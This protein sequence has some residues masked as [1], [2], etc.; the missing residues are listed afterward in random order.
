MNNKSERLNNNIFDLFL[1]FNHLDDEIVKEYTDF[2]DKEKIAFYCSRDG[3]TFGTLDD[4]I[5]KDLENSSSFA[6]MLTKNCLGSKWCLN[7]YLLF[8]KNN[9]INMIMPI[10]VDDVL[11]FK[12]Q[13]KIERINDK[14]EVEK[15]TNYFKINRYANNQ[16]TIDKD[17]G[18][19]YGEIHDALVVLWKKM[20]TLYVNSKKTEKRSFLKAVNNIILEGHLESLLTGKTKFSF[21]KLFRKKLNFTNAEELYIK[22]TL[23][24]E[25]DNVVSEDVL[26]DACLNNN[27]LIYSSAGNGKTELL[28][29]IKNTFQN[30]SRT[31]SLFIECSEFMMSG[32]ASVFSYLYDVIKRKIKRRFTEDHLIG[33]LSDEK[34]II[35]WDG[36]DEIV[37]PNQRVLFIERL[38]EFASDYTNVKYVISS[39]FYEFDD[40]DLSLQRYR[41]L[42]F[43]KEEINKYINSFYIKFDVNDIDSFYFELEKINNDIISNPLFLSQIIVIYK[44]E[45]IIPKTKFEILEKT[46]SYLLQLDEEKVFY[47]DT[48]KQNEMIALVNHLLPYLVFRI[49]YLKDHDP[50]KR[51]VHDELGLEKV[52]LVNKTKDIEKFLESRSFYADEEVSGLLQVFI[53]YYSAEY[54]Y[55]ECFSFESSE[56]GKKLLNKCL[57]KNELLSVLLCKIDKECEHDKDEYTEHLSYLL[58]LGIDYTVYLSISSTLYNQKITEYLVTSNLLTKTI[59]NRDNY[60]YYPFYLLHKYHLDNALIEASSSLFK[61][62][63]DK[64]IL[65]SLLRDYFVIFNDVRDGKGL[66]KDN[67]L[68][69][70]Q[71]YITDHPSY[72]NAL[73]GLF[74]DVHLDGFINEENKRIHPFF[75]NLYLMGKDDPSDGLGE[76]DLDINFVDELNIYQND[77][78]DG[79]EHIGVI[80]LDYDYQRIVKEL[81]GHKINKV[82]GI[83]FNSSNESKLTVLPIIKKNL[84]LLVI[85]SS[86]KELDENS[87]NMFKADIGNSS[88]YIEHGVKEIT[89]AIN[90]FASVYLPNSVTSFKE[91]A[92]IHIFAKKAYLSNS[93]ETITR[94]LFA[95]SPLEY[96]KLPKSLIAIQHYAFSDCTHLKKLELPSTLKFLDARALINTGIPYLYIPQTVYFFATYTGKYM[97]LFILEKDLKKDFGEFF[98]GNVCF[99]VKQDEIVV[100]D[101]FLYTRKGDELYLLRPLKKDYGDTATIPESIDGYRISKIAFHTLRNLETKLFVIP[102]NVEAINDE[103]ENDFLCLSYYSIWLTNA[104]KYS[105]VLDPMTIIVGN[106][107]SDYLDNNLYYIFNKETKLYTYKDGVVYYVMDNQLHIA[108]V[109]VNALTKIAEKVT[110]EGRVY[111]TTIIDDDAFT[112]SGKIDDYH[113]IHIPASVVKFG[114]QDSKALLYVVLDDDSNI[115]SFEESTKE[116]YQN[117]FL[118]DK[119]L[120]EKNGDELTINKYIYDQSGKIIIP[121]ELNGLKVTKV[122]AEYFSNKAIIYNPRDDEYIDVELVKEGELIELIAGDNLKDF[123]IPARI[124]N[125]VKYITSDKYQGKY[126]GST[127]NPYFLVA[128]YDKREIKDYVVHKDTRIVGTLALNTENLYLPKTIRFINS[129]WNDHKYNLYF[130]GSI[131]DYL[132]IHHYVY[133]NLTDVSHM[134]VK[135]GDDYEEVKDV[136]VPGQFKVVTPHIFGGASFINN[137]Y[138]EEGVQYIGEGAFM[139]SGYSAIYLPSSLRGFELEAFNG[140][141][142]LARIY[143]NGDALSWDELD[144][145]KKELAS[146]IKRLYFFI[147][148][149]YRNV[150]DSYNEGLIENPPFYIPGAKVAHFKT[151]Q[152]LIEANIEADDDVE[153]IFIN[154]PREEIYIGRKIIAYFFTEGEESFDFD[155]GFYQIHKDHY[156]NYRGCSYIIYDG[157]AILTHVNSAYSKYIMPNEVFIG[158]NEYKVIGIGNYAIK[159]EFKLRELILPLHIKYYYLKPECLKNIKL[160]HDENGAS[161]LPCLNNPYLLMV[162]LLDD[163]TFTF[164]QEGC[165]YIEI[166]Y[167][168]RHLFP[169]FALYVPE[170]VRTI[171]M[172]DSFSGVNINYTLLFFE[173]DA[174]SDLHT[175]LHISVFTNVKQEN[176][177]QY[178]GYYYI[179]ENNKA[180]LVYAGE[181]KN[182]VTLDEMINGYPLTK[183]GPHCFYGSGVCFNL[184]ETV[185]EVDE[186][187]FYGVY[188]EF[189]SHKKCREMKIYSTHNTIYPFVQVDNLI[190]E[191]SDNLTLFKIIG[192]EPTT[193]K[194]KYTINEKEYSL[195]SVYLRVDNGKNLLNIPS[196]VG[197]VIVS[198]GGKQERNIHYQGTI[199]NLCSRGRLNL[200]IYDIEKGFFLQDNNGN[201]YDICEIEDLSLPMG[202]ETFAFD[203][204]YAY[205][206]SL[207]RITLPSSIKTIDNGNPGIEWNIEEIII[208]QTAHI[209]KI[210]HKAFSINTL[211]K[212][213]LPN[214]IDFID[215]SAFEGSA[216]EEVRL[217]L[218]LSG[219]LMNVE[220]EVVDGDFVVV[221]F[222]H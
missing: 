145:P 110:I 210:G 203:R 205:M 219:T 19:T 150:V 171:A 201:E 178:N 25:N 17:T 124:K 80:S 39:R 158:N 2:L 37:E 46:S 86:I 214:Q 32:A 81:G 139:D 174:V 83:I 204:M 98:Y 35:L 31:L 190:F 73:N 137:I 57:D 141:N 99:G 96:V 59:N 89:S 65:L 140:E 90:G 68:K 10:C 199:K 48:E 66:I 187:A 62:D 215:S 183:I 144:Y 100:H 132:N 87:L 189:V 40:G 109:F 212:V 24:D 29:N 196:S 4:I 208:D 123:F 182:L 217:P 22:R 216:V 191:V 197:R 20:G 104:Y 156:V 115:D 5:K 82:F 105:E 106:L 108:K 94:S 11:S 34:I 168:N 112:E 120:V 41:L 6:I 131:I 36:F 192:N 26:L 188:E 116:Y 129:L 64:D 79:E 135:N 198:G 163:G 61:E 128:D 23:M 60:Y 159:E 93:V 218:H 49:A 76:M 167:D 142:H 56:E 166:N 9:G 177:V 52:D 207:K 18:L 53:D 184:P 92:Y 206:E 209:E 202:V 154:E 15:V 84:D 175:G 143:Y 28:K 47:T 33:L 173:G 161:Y 38:N 8:Y 91:H 114:K 71:E 134:Y 107:P 51:Y 180:T 101:D 75:F 88:L 169:I 160:N 50:I 1:S 127:S 63:I 136:T 72:R 185:V 125:N 85:P 16:E 67:D 118:I 45:N 95:E 69:T 113:L 21:K 55:R 30:Q 126:I 151:K 111:Q 102:N 58:S 176:I 3:T 122:G 186:A 42:S 221:H 74:Y 194:E 220:N 222:K 44:L 149:R 213:E 97:T 130:E 179:I 200:N 12:D 170:S 147:D 138:I 153:E 193:L 27:I 13:T 14:D 119:Y 70:Y 162:D 121:D 78:V 211:K 181:V 155:K 164:V 157:G 148:G 77:I 103:Y 172:K 146:F 152:E 133:V 7:E 195:I 117:H 165:E 43:T 54:L